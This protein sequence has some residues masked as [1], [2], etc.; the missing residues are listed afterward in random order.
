MSRIRFTLHLIKKIFP[1]RHVLAELT[2]VPVLG[3]FITILLFGEDRL[4]YLPKNESLSQT[5]TINVDEPLEA[6]KSVVLPTRVVEYFIRK[7]DYIFKMDFCICRTA[8]NC[9]NYPHDLGCLF[10]GNAARKISHK[11]GKQV[12][13]EEAFQHLEDCREQGLIHLVGKN[14]LDQFWL[15]TDPHEQLFTVCNCCECCCLWQILPYLSKKI[16]NPVKKMS[17]VEIEITEDCIGCGTCVDTCFVNAIHVKNGKARVEESCRGC[18]RC[19]S[20]CPADAIKLTIKDPRFIER[21]I[22]KL[23]N[24]VDISNNTK[25]NL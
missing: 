15:D 16:N 24:A 19:V 9:D 2:K 21:T 13:Q 25:K 22:Q 14:K 18:G 7:A 23:E 1:F 8:E 17:G 5:T 11:V 10:L 4:H 12:T 20:S 3:S 6:P